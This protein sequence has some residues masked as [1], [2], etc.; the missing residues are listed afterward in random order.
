MNNTQIKNKRNIKKFIPPFM[1]KELLFDVNCE[2][3]IYYV[4]SSY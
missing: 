4:G 1:R 3:L 2:Y